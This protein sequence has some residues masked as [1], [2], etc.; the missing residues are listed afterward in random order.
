MASEGSAGTVLKIIPKINLRDTTG[1]CGKRYGPMSHIC[2]TVGACAPQLV[3]H[4]RDRK[5]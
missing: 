5:R 3:Q 4:S 2:M 1:A